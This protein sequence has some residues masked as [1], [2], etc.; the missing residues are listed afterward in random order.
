MF[1]MKSA[2]SLV[3]GFAAVICSAAPA[4]AGLD[5]TDTA[6]VGGFSAVAGTAA[7]DVNGTAADVF[8]SAAMA[9]NFYQGGADLVTF[10]SSAGVGTAATQRFVTLDFS[11]TGLFPNVVETTYATVVGE[12]GYSM[13]LQLGTVAIDSGASATLQ[14][15]SFNDVV[16]GVSSVYFINQAITNSDS[17][18]KFHI[19]IPFGPGGI[20]ATE[21][22]RVDSVRL[23]FAFTGATTSIGVNA[24]VNPEPG[25]F[26]L[27]GLG[28][29]GL[30]GIARR[31]RKRRL[32]TASA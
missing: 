21:R 4:Q 10:S 18:F 22:D 25:T 6:T 15:I 2:L 31:R 16:T 17:G 27:Y 30:A 24:V 11:Y 7:V 20:P 9:S 23:T 29:L 3:I 13:V 28:L 32:A 5:F 14:Q 1:A 19:P 26:A 8:T 12:N